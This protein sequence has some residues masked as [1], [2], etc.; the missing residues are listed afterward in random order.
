MKLRNK[1]LT[2][3]AAVFG[4]AI[5]ALA[6]TISYESPCPSAPAAAVSGE[7]MRAIMQRCYGSPNRVLTVERI[8]KPV[9]KEGQLLI[10]VRATS[11]NPFEWHMTTGKPYL[12]HLFRGLGAPDHPRLGNDVAGVVEAVGPGVSRFKPGDEVFGDIGGG[13]AEFALVRA[14][15]DVVRKPAELT[16][17]E[18]AGIPIAAVTALQGLRNHGHLGPGQ[19]VLINGASGGV[20]TY[21]V[22]IAK[23]LGAEV[24]AVCSTRNVEMVR[25]LGADHVIDY[26][27]EDFT[28]GS[29]HYDLIFDSIGNHGIFALRGVLKPG[30]TLVGIGGSKK[31]PWIGPILGML[32]RKIVDSFVDQHLVGF[33]A[34]MNRPDLEYLA[35]LAHEGKMRTVIDRRYPLEGTGDA[36]EYI[37]SQHARGKVIVTLE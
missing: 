5:A 7:S 24:T 36:L 15:G 16:F 35:N 8:A 27:K 25:S 37:G 20:G 3:V 21:A 6:I 29:E 1:I 13:L 11:L 4:V 22:Q 12:V 23:S 2:G 32:K 19:K 31:E 10:Q 17:E 14:D 9:P 34:E 33:I 28:E 30:G 26:T 18:A